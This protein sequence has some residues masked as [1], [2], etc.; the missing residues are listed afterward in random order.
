MIRFDFSGISQ[1]LIGGHGIDPA[2]LEAL[3]P[4][5]DAAHTEIL[6]RRARGEILFYDLPDQQAALD[7]VTTLAAHLERRFST[8]V[9]LGIGGSS[10]GPR[11]L[12]TALKPPLHN[13]HSRPRI[14]FIDNVDP[15]ELHDLFSCGI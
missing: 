6:E 9:H 10:L 13:L 3:S 14:F 4:A 8:I 1:A 2:D 11:T 15:E 7:E 5:I 12:F